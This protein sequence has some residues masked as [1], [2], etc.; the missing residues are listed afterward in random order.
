[1]A[2]QL[3]DFAVE[4]AFRRSDVEDFPQPPKTELLASTGVTSQMAVLEQFKETANAILRAFEEAKAPR[5]ESVGVFRINMLP[6]K[7]VRIP[8]DA[9]LERDGEGFVARTIEL[10]LYGYGLDP[11]DAINMLKDEIESLYDDLIEDD[12]F[13]D[14][15]IRA[16]KYLSSRISDR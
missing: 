8:I 15:W 9:I 3:H 16:R 14:D 7:E 11:I 1:M 5:S 10:P 6:N 13:T 12:D 4:K 2:A